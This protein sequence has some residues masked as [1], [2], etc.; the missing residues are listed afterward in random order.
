MFMCICDLRISLLSQN[1]LTEVVLQKENVFLCEHLLSCSFLLRLAQFTSSLFIH[2]Y[3]QNC[4]L[5]DNQHVCDSQLRASLWRLRD[6]FSKFHW[7]G[8]FILDP[9]LRFYKYVRGLQKCETHCLYH[10]YRSERCIQPEQAR[11]DT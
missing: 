8:L 11:E 9:F 6:L 5:Y 10:K 7:P 2:T 1:A 4:K 3:T